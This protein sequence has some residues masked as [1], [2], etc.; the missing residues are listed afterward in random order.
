[1]KGMNEIT[2][3]HLVW[4]AYCFNQSYTFYSQ[5]PCFSVTSDMQILTILPVLLH[6]Y[7]K[8]TKKQDFNKIKGVDIENG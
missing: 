7:L 5:Q 6:L 4:R 2:D 1:M 8:Q 3:A